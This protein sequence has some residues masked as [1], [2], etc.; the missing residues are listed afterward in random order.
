MDCEDA[1]CIDGLVVEVTGSVEAGHTIRV[2][3]EGDV[4]AWQSCSA[5]GCPSVVVGSGPAEARVVVNDG[6]TVLA[7]EVVR[8][9][10]VDAQPNGPSCPPTCRSAVVRVEVAAPPETG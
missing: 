3:I 4:V 8:P 2:F 9:D 7:D 10:Y 5:A 1:G 6:A